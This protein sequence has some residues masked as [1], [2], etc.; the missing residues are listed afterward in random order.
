[1]SEQRHS[2]GPWTFE[3]STTKC[4]MT[5]ADGGTVF[6]I[7]GGM[8][9]TDRDARRIVACVNACEGISTHDIEALGLQ[10]SG[11][12]DLRQQRDDLLAALEVAHGVVL[13]A[14]DHGADPQAITAIEAMAR[15]AVAKCKGA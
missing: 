4:R 8:L 3:R 1:M 2:P 11:T 12:P 15:E 14:A 9:P 13:W 6:A 7:N 10:L 5:G